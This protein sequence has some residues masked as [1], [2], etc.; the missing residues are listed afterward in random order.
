MLIDLLPSLIKFKN[1]PATHVLDNLFGEGAVRNIV[2]YPDRRHQRF[3]LYDFK[4]FIYF[5]W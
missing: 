3:C 2:T 1:L 4:C 5:Y